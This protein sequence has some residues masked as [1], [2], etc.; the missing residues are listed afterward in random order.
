MGADVKLSI[1]MFCPSCPEKKNLA[2]AVDSDGYM[3]P[4]AREDSM[5]LF[6][7]SISGAERKYRC[8]F[9]VEEPG[10]VHSTIICSVRGKRSHSGFV[11]NLSSPKSRPPLLRGPGNQNQ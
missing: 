6:I 1:S 7:A 4:A 8:P 11:K 5:Y 2:P 9:G 10:K 3:T